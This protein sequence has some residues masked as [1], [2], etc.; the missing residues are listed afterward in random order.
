MACDGH[1]DAHA[2]RTKY[3]YCVGYFYFLSP[4]TSAFR[5]DLLSVLQPGRY[6]LLLDGQRPTFLAKE[7]R[8]VCCTISFSAMSDLYACRSTEDCDE[9]YDSDDKELRAPPPHHF[10]DVQESSSSE[11][12]CKFLADSKVLGKQ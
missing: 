3:I 8:A 6:N 2:T 5:A 11:K 7:R 4:G 10:P 1:D 12:C 9:H